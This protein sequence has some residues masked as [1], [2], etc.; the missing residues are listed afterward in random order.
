MVGKE[1]FPGRCP[2]GASGISATDRPVLLAGIRFDPQDPFRMDFIFGRS[3]IPQDDYQKRHEYLVLI[4]DFLTALTLPNSD[5]WVNLSPY[6]KDRIIPDNFGLTRMGRDVLEQDFTL[7][8]IMA[9]LYDPRQDSGRIFWKSFYIEALAQARED[10]YN[11]Y[12]ESFRKGM[13]D[14]IQEERD[15]LTDEM[16][17][18]K[19]FSGGILP[20]ER[21]DPA[22]SAQDVE[23]GD[24]VRV[25]LKHSATYAGSQ[26]ARLIALAERLSAEDAAKQRERIKRDLPLGSVVFEGFRQWGLLVGMS[27]TL[28]TA[29][30]LVTAEWSVRGGE[31]AAADH[32]V[33]RVVSAGTA[34]PPVSEPARLVRNSNPGLLLEKTAGE[35]IERFRNGD[36]TAY[37]WL[38]QMKDLRP[39][40]E[41]EYQQNM[42]VFVQAFLDRGASLSDFFFGYDALRALQKADW[43][44]LWD[45][46]S[47]GSLADINFLSKFDGLHEVAQMNGDRGGELS[48]IIDRVFLDRDSL[49]KN[50]SLWARGEGEKLDGLLEIPESARSDILE[51]MRDLST[52]QRRKVMGKIPQLQKEIM[53]FFPDVAWSDDELGR[54]L[55]SGTFEHSQFS[56]GL[57]EENRMFLEVRAAIMADTQGLPS[58]LRRA[59]RGQYLA[60][61]LGHLEQD[62]V[63][64]IMRDEDSRKIVAKALLNGDI[65]YEDIYNV[66][67]VLRE[68]IINRPENVP[69]IRKKIASG[70]VI[71][72]ALFAELLEN[73]SFEAKTS[74]TREEQ[75]ADFAEDSALKGGI[76]LDAR[77]LDLQ[78]QRDSGGFLLPVS[79]QPLV[80]RDLP[81]LVPVIESIEPFDYFSS[82]SYRQ[83][84]SAV[85]SK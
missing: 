37:R 27:L 31:Q 45:R 81:G 76:D 21:V 4:G 65:P 47:E 34:K 55:R 71:V 3:G 38:A 12:L 63:Q 56:S 46:A 14:F 59:V 82:G 15:P 84:A 83:R 85:L 62:A 40:L 43:T 50:V 69:V 11:A 22:D 10:I 68:Y 53:D 9:A 36:L 20:P 64:E 66:P 51:M 41:N 48:D 60:E 61:V 44:L 32:F 7:K 6:E 58:F 24:V 78:I 39:D 52:T 75:S 23:T 29:V 8:Q 16:I 42:H 57:S 17:P 13:F 25:R 19:Y 5:M 70:D 28:V 35:M 2:D 1:P 67:Q 54:A 79:S 73:L 72:T 26:D 49:R 74:V 77:W 30:P 80:L 18:R 33:S